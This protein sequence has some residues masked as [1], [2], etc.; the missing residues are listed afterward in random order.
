MSPEHFLTVLKG[1]EAIVGNSSVA[2]REC[3]FMGVAAIN[4]GGRQA[5]R[6]RGSNVLDCDYDSEEIFQSIN[7]QLS[8]K[9]QIK[10]DLLYGDGTA[11]KEIAEVLANHDVTIEKMLTY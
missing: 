2:I 5:G 4:I 9:S 3:A 6:D 1:A 7:Y 11:G 10:S 8:N